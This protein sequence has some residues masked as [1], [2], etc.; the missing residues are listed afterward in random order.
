MYSSK[1]DKKG[2]LKYGEI[3][4][5]DGYREEINSIGSTRSV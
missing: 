1:Y 3:K 4:G 5:I 2:I